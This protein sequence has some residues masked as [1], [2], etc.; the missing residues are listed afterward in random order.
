MATGKTKVRGRIFRWGLRALAVLVVL[1]VLTSA[2]F[3]WLS[4]SAQSRWNCLASEIRATGQPLT[5]ADIEASRPTIPD[6]LNGISTIEKT[7]QA[8]DS[9]STPGESGVFFLDKKCKADFFEEIDLRCVAP[10]RKYLEARRKGLNELS[11]VL[12]FARIRLTVTYDGSCFS[13]VDKLLKIASHH[14]HL[15]K[16][17]HLDTALKI[18]D[19]DIAGAID[20]IRVQLRLSEPLY[21]EP[22]YIARISATAV[23]WSTFTSIEGLLRAREL[24]EDD[25]E[26]LQAEC[27]RHVKLQTIRPSLL[28]ERASL[29]SLTDL[30][31]ITAA[32]RAMIAKAG[33]ALN[34]GWR[35]SDLLASIP[36][37]RDWSTRFLY[38]NRIEGVKLLTRLLDASD[39][40]SALIDMAKRQQASLSQA[41]SSQRLVG[42]S[43]S[44]LTRGFEMHAR[45][46]AMF[47]CAAVALAAERF[48][49]STGRFPETLTQLVP[50]YLPEIPHDPFDSKPIRFARNDS[51][52]IVY[53]VGK[54]LDDDGGTVAPREGERFGRD[55]S[56][57]ILNPTLRGLRLLETSAPGDHQHSPIGTSAE[58]GPFPESESSPNSGRTKSEKQL[59]PV[60]WGLIPL[61]VP[62]DLGQF[63]GN[64]VHGVPKSPNRSASIRL[65]A[66]P[67]RPLGPSLERTGR[68]RVSRE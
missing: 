68:Q 49:L 33:S 1:F 30:D 40:L 48:R 63:R 7:A 41:T 42:I 4:R 34:S 19:G 32:K 27:E 50:D 14:R 8:L 61:A 44:S 53:S 23:D 20:A 26:R 39:N 45:S 67:R 5:F 35:V 3:Y 15:G 12:H 18:I 46:V 36:P 54:N 13:A 31:Q 60:P 66:Q 28:G 58:Q 56:F 38:A 10:T 11:D 55:V 47:R 25:L 21:A 17:V 64:S 16:L 29:I 6:D 24:A 65:R 2:V 37:V 51:G 9:I 59:G 52:I 43:I 57:R 62:L 22:A